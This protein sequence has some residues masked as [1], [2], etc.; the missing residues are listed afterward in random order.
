MHEQLECK[1]F[2]AC[3]LD[4][5]KKLNKSFVCT[6]TLQAQVCDCPSPSILTPD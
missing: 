3:E 4:E 6:V 1:C 5:K 2:R